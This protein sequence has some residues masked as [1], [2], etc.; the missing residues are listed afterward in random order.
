M[1]APLPSGPALLRL[2]GGLGLALL[3]VGAE[4]A[5]AHLAATRP[6]LGLWGASALLGLH[7]GAAALG[8][9]ALRLRARGAPAAH[10]WLGAALVLLLPLLG[11]LALL[12]FAV[13][14]PRVGHAAAGGPSQEV[15][16][17]KAMAD[18]QDERR[19]AQTVDADV[20]SIVDAL[21]DPDVQVRLGAMEALR[22]MHG[23]AAVRL[24]KVSR[25]NTVFDVRFRAVEALG[26]LSQ[27]A[28][29]QV[30]HATAAVEAA[31]DNPARWAELGDA[32]RGHHDLG[33]EDDVQQRSLLVQAEACYRT[34][35]ELSP[36]DRA[37]ALAHA[38]SL[39]RVG[40]FEEA[41]EVLAVAL[42]LTEGAASGSGADGGP[43]Y[44]AQARL[45][46]RQ[47][48]I[49]ALPGL[50]RQ[51]LRADRGALAEDERRALGYWADEGGAK[52]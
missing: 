1:R 30:A 4:L 6:A 27:R 38:E 36:E 35:A 31:L 32:Y 28:S 18:L 50:C 22:G 10:A 43:V 33:V 40:R 25:T 19:L 7:L 41:R 21:K 14:P 3:A 39:E 47:G 20:Q 11:V 52:A 5:A 15:Q 12:V 2:A 46:F 9:E 8:G 17:A 29:D 37:Y 45:A 16:R 49:D 51:A 13:A 44:Y 48:R 24:L 23:A 42:A 26:E 34:A